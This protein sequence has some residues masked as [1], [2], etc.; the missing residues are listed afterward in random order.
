MPHGIDVWG[1]PSHLLRLKDGR[2][3]MSYG[4]RRAPFGNQAR[5]SNDHGKTWSETLTIS[6][7]GHTGDLGYP[8]T[9]EC[10]D[11]T[12]ITVWYELLKDSPNAQLRQAR[13]K[14]A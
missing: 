3:L 10:E 7:D 6:A 8:S 5:I 14:L 13:W 9:V 2:L 11:G 1:L 12:L 4:H